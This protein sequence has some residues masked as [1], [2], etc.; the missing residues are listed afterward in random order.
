MKKDQNLPNKN[1][2]IVII[3][4]ENHFQV[5]QITQETNH[6]ITQVIEIDRPNKEIHEISYKIDIADRIAKITKI[7]IHIEFKHNRIC[8]CIQ[9]P[10]KPKEQTL[11]Q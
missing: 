11:S 4:Q 6:H 3:V 7:T 2:Y 1:I 5:T 8:F 9:F 10:F